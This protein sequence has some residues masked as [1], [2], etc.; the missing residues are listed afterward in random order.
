VRDVTTSGYGSAGDGS[1]DMEAPRGGPAV[2]FEMPSQGPLSISRARD[3][4]LGG[5]SAYAPARHGARTVHRGLVEAEQ[6][7]TQERVIRS[8]RAHSR[9]HVFTHA[10]TDTR[11]CLGV[12]FAPALRLRSAD[13]H[14]AHR[15][16]TRLGIVIG[17][18]G[19]GG[20]AARATADR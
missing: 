6:M 15:S 19:A 7:N 2:A 20:A 11:G 17:A 3:G 13:A 4:P 12:S 10:L 18:V 14:N 9:I 8:T 5:A 1:D 16:P